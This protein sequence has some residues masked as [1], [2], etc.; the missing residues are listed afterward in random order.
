MLNVRLLKRVSQKDV[1]PKALRPACRDR[2]AH[3]PT[4][5]GVKYL[6]WLDLKLSKTI[7]RL[8]SSGQVLK[9]I[10]RIIDVVT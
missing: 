8:A 3:R 6:F 5:L 1:A 4:D 9:D 10:D 7:T 2:S